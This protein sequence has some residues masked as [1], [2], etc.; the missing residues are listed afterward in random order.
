MTRLIARRLLLAIPL[1]F[2]VSFLTFALTALAP[3]DPATTILGASATPQQV[4]A[5][6]QQLGLS[7]PI[8]L[9]YWHWL[10]D[11][12]Q[13]DLGVS[14]V[15]SQ[16]VVDAIS[17]RLPVT[18]SLVVGATLL[19][20]VLGVGLGVFSA[21]RGGAAGRATDALAMVGFAIPNFWLGWV[22][23]Y[24][25]AVKAQ[26]LPATGYVEF[27]E[28]PSGWLE[29]LILPVITL[30]AV[31][32]TGIAKQTRDA[33]RE[34]MS[35]EFIGTLRAAGISESRI[36]FRHALKNA[37]IPVVTVIGLFFVGMLGGAV[38]VETVFVMPGLGSLAVSSAKAGDLTL[39]EGTVVVFCIGVVIANLFVDV[40]YG[41][42]N[43]RARI[44]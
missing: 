44:R 17:S 5:L 4:S 38:L 26:L 39:V 16:P 12:V 8:W 27:A 42:L 22:L 6:S 37:A 28:S 2:V 36:V 7:D 35:R 43:P 40:A 19:S 3:G 41:W 18:L 30:A 21:V 34:A 14:L 33:M 32:V 10:Q 13:G 20:A 29:S 23:V 31:G 25:F 11:A 15:S 1:I 9:Q 24:F